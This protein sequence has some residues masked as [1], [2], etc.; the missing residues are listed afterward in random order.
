MA[1]TLG[2]WGADKKADLAQM[3]Q[4]EQDK[5]LPTAKIISFGRQALRRSSILLNAFA[6]SHRVQDVLSQDVQRALEFV[7][8][9]RQQ[10]AG[11]E[12]EGAQ[13]KAEAA[14]CHERVFGH[15][16]VQL[17][18]AP[19]SLLSCSAGLGRCWLTWT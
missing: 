4:E 8:T 3:A 2:R 15:F 6:K 14:L 16:F 7:A 17:A 9:R 12:L 11:R 19:G 5:K 18:C 13:H 10:A 1:P